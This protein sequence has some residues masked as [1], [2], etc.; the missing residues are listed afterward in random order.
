MEGKKKMEW[1]SKCPDP[2]T[3]LDWKRICSKYNRN[4]LQ[5]LQFGFKKIIAGIEPLDFSGVVIIMVV[6]KAVKTWFET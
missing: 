4:N 6:F 2:A 1:R 3:K 5:L